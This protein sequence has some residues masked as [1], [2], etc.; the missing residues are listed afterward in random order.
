MNKKA[1]SSAIDDAAA[2]SNNRLIVASVES[3]IS[4]LKQDAYMHIK[5]QCV[6]FTVAQ[7]DVYSC[8]KGD[9]VTCDNMPHAVSACMWKGDDND[10]THAEWH[11]H[12]RSTWSFS[13][14][15]LY[16]YTYIA[17]HS[18]RFALLPAK[19]K[20]QREN[21]LISSFDEHLW[22]D[23]DR[24]KNYWILI[25]SRRNERKHNAH[26]K[27]EQLFHIQLRNHATFIESSNCWWVDER[28]KR[29]ERKIELFFVVFAEFSSIK[30]E[31]QKENN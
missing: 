28:T 26:S 14:F 6:P 5:V 9:V 4:M 27:E 2:V 13:S 15:H 25:C 29:K 18:I 11:W 12:S 21:C 22:C 16:F 19:R 17:I 1:G 30:I 20:M 8:A 10:N 23:E 7:K 31:M 24:E 3:T